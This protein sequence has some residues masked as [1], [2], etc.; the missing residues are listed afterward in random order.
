MT[1]TKRGF[2]LIELLVVVLIIGILA[3]VALPQYQKAVEKARLAE[4][5]IIASSLEKAVDAW[6]L[7]NGTPSEQISFLGNNSNGKGQLD[8]DIESV[9]DCSIY[10][11]TECGN[12]N[13]SYTADCENTRCTI[14]IGRMING[15]RNHVP[16]VIFKEKY[17][18]TS[19]WKGGDCDYFTDEGVIGKQI[20]K[21]LESQGNGF[22]ACENC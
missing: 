5:F 11:G 7:A 21:W 20:C 2:T 15:D 22:E 14:W 10:N 12:K 18:P 6:L 3:A 19:A 8:I 17:S 1:Q 4:A 9:M 13:F 16:Y